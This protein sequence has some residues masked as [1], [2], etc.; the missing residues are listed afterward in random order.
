MYF[1]KGRDPVQSKAVQRPA[2]RSIHDLCV[3]IGSSAMLWL[4]SEGHGAGEGRGRGV[5]PGIGANG[6]KVVKR[7]GGDGNKG[8]LG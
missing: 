1:I 8:Q 4:P 7:G 3:A 6:G 2:R 5:D